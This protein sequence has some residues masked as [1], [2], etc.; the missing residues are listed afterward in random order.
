MALIVMTFGGLL[1]IAVLLEDP[2]A[3]ETNFLANILKS[4]FSISG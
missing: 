4:C 1:R 3:A 2:D